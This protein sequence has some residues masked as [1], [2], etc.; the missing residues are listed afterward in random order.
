[1]RFMISSSDRALAR[2]D[3]RRFWPLLF[4]Y[5]VVWLCVLPLAL[6]SNRRWIYDATDSAASLASVNSHL[7]G[8]TAAAPII[9]AC[10]AVLLA[11]ALFAYLMNSRSVG[12]MHAL[13]VRRGRQFAVH[14][15]AGVAMFTVVH[16][17]A[18]LLSLPVQAALGAVDLR[19]TMEWLAVAE[20]SAL[21]FFALAVL[22]AMVTGWLLAIPVI[23]AGVNF[24]FAAFYFLFVGVC[25]IF[26]WGYQ[27]DGWPTW[28]EWLTPLVRM[29]RTVGMN[30]SILYSEEDGTRWYVS[31]LSAEAWKTLAVYTVVAV[32]FVAA[33]YFFYRLRHSETAGDAIVF[34]WL[35][36]VVLYVIALAG[37]LGLGLL[38]WM[39]I[40]NDESF[41]GLAV[42]QVV[43]GLIVFFG[44]RMLLHKSFRVF[45]RRGWI[46]AAA[47]TAALLLVAGVVKL[48]VFGVEKFVPKTEQ[49]AYA[50]VLTYAGNGSPNVFNLSDPEGLEKLAAF[51]R[52]ILAQ[53]QTGQK[54]IERVN[55]I[56]T[57]EYTGAENYVTICMTYVMKDG[58][59]VRRS[60]SQIIRRNTPLYEAANAFY[61]DPAV[62]AV[63]VDGRYGYSEIDPASITGGWFNNYTVNEDS[64]ALTGTQARRLY[65]AVKNYFESK[66]GQPVDIL[67]PDEENNDYCA[68]YLEFNYIDSGAAG[69]PGTVDD[70]RADTLCWSV[71]NL[72]SDC[73]EVLELL[74]SFG[75]VKDTAELLMSK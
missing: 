31:Y 64:T 62:R 26:Y 12:L 42:C 67:A 46:G 50:N 19:G 30:E 33:A 6:W 69:T 73:T 17:A 63:S 60:Y 68:F 32:L 1:M 9:S 4:G 2:A 52:E 7:W 61:N 75:L 15:A 35:R 74:V 11:M 49:V 51:H 65:L 27:S 8:C 70:T 37:G 24:M 22:C 16:V 40:R 28:I 21:I 56:P 48:D 47:L 43:I 57:S 59:Y 38:L 71:D 14:F 55:S 36:P 66:R 44:V 3:F 53:G 10:F 41:V 34:P 58:S 25:Q 13:P 29:V 39:M 54:E 23:F 5:A 20:L 18:A 72:P 45:D